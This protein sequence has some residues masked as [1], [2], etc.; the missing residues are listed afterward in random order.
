MLHDYPEALESV[1]L[2]TSSGGVFEITLDGEVIFSKKHQG[3]F[4]EDAEL[5]SHLEALP[6]VQAGRE[7]G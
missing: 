4:P 5:L 3:R 2:L 7:S 1:T 6:A